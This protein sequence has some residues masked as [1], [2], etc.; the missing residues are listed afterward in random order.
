MRTPDEKTCLKCHNADSPTFKGFDYKA[1][2]AKIEHH[3]PP[4]A[5]STATAPK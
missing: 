2:L 3:I 1:A 5:D 4:K